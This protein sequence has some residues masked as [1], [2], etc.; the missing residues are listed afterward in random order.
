MHLRIQRSD[1][2]VLIG[3]DA[4]AAPAVAN[5]THLGDRSGGKQLLERLIEEYGIHDQEQTTMAL[6]QFFNHTREG[7]DLSS[8]L[9]VWRLYLEE[10]IELGGLQ[11][12]N[13]AKSY[14]LLRCSGLP[15]QNNFN[16]IW[17]ILNRMA[18]SETAK[19]ANSCHP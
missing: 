11:L 7:H 15:K 12:N 16:E 9:T 2:T 18:K 14:I 19:E 1:G 13:V 5:S 4:V 17:A 10:A 3:P 6:D 8:Y